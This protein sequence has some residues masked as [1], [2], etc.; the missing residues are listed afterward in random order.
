MKLAII[1][2]G[3]SGSTLPLAKHLREHGH[4]VTCFYLVDP[5][6]SSLE[7]IDFDRC[8][9]KPGIHTV[10][11]SSIN[12]YFAGNKILIYTVVLVRKRQKL[13]SYI[14][15]KIIGKIDH[16]TI[17]KLCNKIKQEK[18]DLINLVGH[19]HPMEL[20]GEYLTDQKLFY[21]LHEVMKNHANTKADANVVT[22][23]ALRHN[24]PIVVHSLKSFNDVSAFSRELSSVSIIKLI[25]FG[26]FETFLEC[27][28]I[29]YN[30]GKNDGFLLFIGYILPYKGLSILF[31]ACKLLEKRKKF[32]FNIIV[33]GKGYDS[34]LP[35]LKANK[36]IILKNE[37]ITNK[38]LVHL[39]SSC[40][41]VVCPY[42]SAS[43]SGIPQ[44][45]SLFNKP[46]IASNV[47]AF[48]EV[49]KTGKN[50]ILIEPGDKEGLA[51][52]I[53]KIMCDKQYYDNLFSKQLGTEESYL[54]DWN[55]ICN[56]YEEFF[57]EIVN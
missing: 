12:H 37:Y 52:A 10:K 24:I 30:E 1:A 40:K 34:I 35:T 39:V 16:N 19:T 3:F 26:E 15:N 48:P 13:G 44:V 33:A 31:E 21:S 9:V 55:F 56:Q 38:E 43:Q 45:A 49:I 51:D 6:T 14:L 8:Y 28:R 27:P 32:N 57:N 29:N 50:G 20:I 23:F 2:Y 11:S 46:I 42:L 36:K 22:L 5:F 7:G 18:Y 41:A 4:I 47:G 53:E 54:Y 25:H 17:Y